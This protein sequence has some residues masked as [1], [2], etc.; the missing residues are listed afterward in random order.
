MKQLL[1]NKKYG[2][3]KLLSNNKRYVDDLITFNYLYFHNLIR[4]IYP[5]SLDMERA[6]DNNKNVNYLDLNV[7]IEADCISV[8]VYNMQSR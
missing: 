3:A 1:K 8:S 5:A 6:G 4:S 7:S 2:L